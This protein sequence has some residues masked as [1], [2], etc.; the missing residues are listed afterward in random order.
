MTR[1]PSGEASART[2]VV[3]RSARVY[4]VGYPEGAEEDDANLPAE[5]LSLAVVE[6]DAVRLVWALRSGEMD[7]ALLPSRGSR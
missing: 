6:E 4:D 7:V 2:E 3:L 5:W 1:A